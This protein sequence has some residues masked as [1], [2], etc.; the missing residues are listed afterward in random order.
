MTTILLGIGIIAIFF[1]LMSVRL[2]F[3]KKGEFK[4]TCASQNPYL[5]KDGAACGFCGKTVQPGDSCGNPD[6]EV[7]KLLA[8]FEK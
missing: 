6:N 8:K 4:G 1:V 7:D 3:L 5:N 2:I